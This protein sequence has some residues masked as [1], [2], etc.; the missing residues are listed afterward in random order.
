M[1]TVKESRERFGA[2]AGE[3][4]RKLKALRGLKAGYWLLDE[5]DDELAL[6]HTFSGTLVSH[7]VTDSESLAAAA[8]DLAAL[9]KKVA[10][11][12]F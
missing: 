5:V 7:F 8:Q 6:T 3:I 1:K 11:A 12:G 4:E 10:E 2:D 9:A